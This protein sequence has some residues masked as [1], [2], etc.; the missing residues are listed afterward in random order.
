MS[1]TEKEIYAS[2]TDTTIRVYQAYNA[3][4]ATRAVTHQTFVSPPFKPDR[5]TWIKPS[6]CWMMERCGWASKENQEHVL[7]VD[8]SRE[9]FRW[10]LENAVLSHYDGKIHSSYEQWKSQL[11]SSPV[12]IQ[13]DPERDL[14][15]NKLSYRSIQIGLKPAAV[16]HYVNEW[17]LQITDITPLVKEIKGLIDQQDWEAAIGLLPVESVIEYKFA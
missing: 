12:V 10:A 2:S 4:I 13:W 11:D 17:I 16:D 6:F 5:T 14:Q 3:A 9:G 15:G 7:A 1:R 8:I